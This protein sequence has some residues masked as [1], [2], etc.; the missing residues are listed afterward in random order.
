MGRSKKPETSASVTTTQTD[1]KP[2]GKKP[3]PSKNNPIRKRGATVKKTGIASVIS[4]NIEDKGIIKCILNHFE[5][6]K[7]NPTDNMEASATQGLKGLYKKNDMP[8]MT[9]S[10]K[11]V[12]KRI[13]NS[14][15]TDQTAISLA[16]LQKDLI[17]FLLDCVRKEHNV[18]RKTLTPLSIKKALSGFYAYPS[19]YLKAEKK[20]D[21]T[22][23]HYQS[24]EA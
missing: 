7:K 4:A 22:L 15:T 17:T 24:Q 12:D 18:A 3:A 9:V 14:E 6:L 23:D 21:D 16:Q 2:I 13:R 20:I 5:H 10:E 19:A 1:K 11:E 8:N